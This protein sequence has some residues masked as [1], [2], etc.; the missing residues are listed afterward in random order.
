MV[1]SGHTVFADILSPGLAQTLWRFDGPSPRPRFSVPGSL[2]PGPLGIGTGYAAVGNATVGVTTLRIVGPDTYSA[3][4]CPDRQQVVFIDPRSGRQSIITTLPK[5]LK[6]PA[7]GCVG[8]WLSSGQ[9]VVSGGNLWLLD[10]E[11]ASFGY[12]RLYRIGLPAL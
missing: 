5:G 2:M 11:S 9:A 8:D 1:A 6:G 12:A 7:Y 3:S 10:G 4:T